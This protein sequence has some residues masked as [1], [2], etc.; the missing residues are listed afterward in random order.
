MAEPVFD[1]KEVD[2]GKG[3]GILSYIGILA[4]IPYF[5]EKN[6]KFV[7]FH[8]IQGMNLMLVLVAYGI[9]YWIISFVVTSIAMSNCVTTYYGYYA[10]SCVGGGIGALIVSSIFGLIGLGLGIIAII[11][12]VNA[13]SGKAKELPLIGKIKIIKK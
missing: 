4:L 13:A 2:S 3:M 10:S 1:K 5:A 9:I 12:I 8:A 6:N 11:G 7:R